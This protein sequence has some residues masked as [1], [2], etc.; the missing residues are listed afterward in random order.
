M[1]VQIYFTIELTKN[2]GTVEVTEIK[3]NMDFDVIDKVAKKNVQ[4]RSG[5]KRSFNLQSREVS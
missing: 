5:G 4:R 3:E 2:D 1:E